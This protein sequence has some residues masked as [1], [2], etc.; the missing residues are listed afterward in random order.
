M[1]TTD[2]L[3]STEWLAAHLNDPDAL[4]LQ[5]I[6]EGAFTGHHGHGSLQRFKI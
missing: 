4:L 5:Q 3:V 1:P 6:E 2:P